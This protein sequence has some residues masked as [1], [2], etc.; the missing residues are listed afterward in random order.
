MAKITCEFFSTVL[1]LNTT[2]TVLIPDRELSTEEHGY[3]TL[4]LLHGYSDN[5]SAWTRRTS[6]ERYAEEAGI[7]V[8]MPE[9]DHSF[10]TDMTYGKKY[11]TFLTKELPALAR[12]LFPLSDR[13]VDN[14]VAGLSMGGY[15]AF[16]WA[17]NCPDQFAAAAS[18]SGVLDLAAHQELTPIDEPIAKSLKHAFGD[19]PLGRTMHDILYLIEQHNQDSQVKPMLYQACGTEDFLYQ[20]NVTF[21]ERVGQTEFQVKT[22]F[23]PGTHEWGYWDKHI[24]NVINW[25][26]L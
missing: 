4:Y 22:V 1:N 17:L 3:K 13:R 20:G 14:F 15:G 11:W 12:K 9:V 10:Y 5:H 18:L 26:P 25:L 19:E 2:M 8:V 6:I 21:K 7:A 23:D 24:Q 16:K